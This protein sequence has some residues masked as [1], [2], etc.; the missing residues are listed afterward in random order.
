MGTQVK[1]WELGTNSF[2]DGWGRGPIAVGTAGDGAN[3]CGG[4]K[5]PFFQN[6]TGQLGMGQRSK[7]SW[8]RD[9]KLIPVQLSNRVLGRNTLL[10]SFSS[11][12][13]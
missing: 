7:D 11:V 1:G 4:T 8:E 10:I 13:I 9:E 5:G 6:C 2:G 12:E 3:S